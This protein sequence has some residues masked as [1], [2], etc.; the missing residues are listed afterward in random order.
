[1]RTIDKLLEEFKN[2]INNAKAKFLEDVEAIKKKHETP[3]T[4]VIC[5]VKIYFQYEEF[6]DRSLQ[7]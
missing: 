2:D 4:E 1:M 6:R 7:D 3:H 5:D